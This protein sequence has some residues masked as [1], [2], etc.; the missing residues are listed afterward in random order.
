MLSI[1]ME[2]RAVNVRKVW[3]TYRPVMGE[4]LENGLSSRLEDYRLIV[5]RRFACPNDLESYAGGSV[6]SW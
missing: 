4:K 2:L 1:E 6:S 3:I 5:R